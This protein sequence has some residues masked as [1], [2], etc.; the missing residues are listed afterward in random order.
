MGPLGGR[1]ADLRHDDRTQIVDHRAAVL[2][3]RFG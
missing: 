1:R 2:I 3:V